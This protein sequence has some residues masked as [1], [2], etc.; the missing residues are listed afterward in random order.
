MTTMLNPA[1]MS[2]SSLEDTMQVKDRAR[3]TLT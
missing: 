3:L 2:K 1:I